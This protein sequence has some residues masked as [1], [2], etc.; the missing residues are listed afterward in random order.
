M[1]HLERLFEYVNTID[2]EMT[3]NL[4]RSW[5][6]PHPKWFEFRK[7]IDKEEQDI[8]KRW[9]PVTIFTELAATGETFADVPCGFHYTNRLGLHMKD[10]GE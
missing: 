5:N 3:I 10:E 2:K 4:K 6:Y 9:R 1:D 7:R 8:L